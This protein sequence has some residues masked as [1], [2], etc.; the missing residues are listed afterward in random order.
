MELST[1]LP[2]KGRLGSCVG[3]AG[4]DED[5]LRRGDCGPRRPR[6]SPQAPRPSGADVLDL[7]LLEQV[8]D[9]ARVLLHDVVLAAD[10]RGRSSV[11][12]ATLMPCLGR[13]DFAWW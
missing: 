7:V 5:E 2:S 11:T 8:G 10:H 6:A 1:F 3:A 13:T 4:G 12:P 9:A